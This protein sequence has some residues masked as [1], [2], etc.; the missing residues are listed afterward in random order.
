MLFKIGEFSRLSHLTVKTL[1]FYEKEGLLIPD[2][3][4][5]LSS[6]RYYSTSSL[7]EACR[8]KAFRQLGLSIEEIKR[9]KQ[10]EDLK[11][12]L[13]HKSDEL[14]KE[15]EFIESKISILNCLLKEENMKYQPVIKDIEECVVYYGETKLETYGDMMNFIP[16]LG[17]ECARLNP[18]LKCIEPDYC[19]CEYLDGEYKESDIKVRYCQAVD[20]FGKESSQIS[21]KK[22]DGTRVISILHKG[23]YDML[24][25]A[26]AYIIKYAKENKYQIKGL[27][28]ECYID[29]IWNKSDVNEYL[30]E[31]Q[32]PVD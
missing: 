26:Y 17:E 22:L 11:E 15:K 23:S 16:A 14:I 30:T 21:F 9:I 1:R 6:Y 8:I 3:V 24:G 2:K 28:R 27:P 5:S 13:K 31:I 4:D 29:G 25:E 10:G 20:R 32:L 19:F 12:I 18:D 7:E